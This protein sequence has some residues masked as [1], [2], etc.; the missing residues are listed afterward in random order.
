MTLILAL[1]REKMISLETNLAYIVSS[2]P[3]KATQQ[4][5]VPK[6]NQPTQEILPTTKSWG[7]DWFVLK[8][9]DAK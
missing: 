1:G 3:E 2:R 8:Q 4:D 7:F 9:G 5:L 6:K